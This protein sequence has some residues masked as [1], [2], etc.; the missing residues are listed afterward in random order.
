M[1]PV[2][3]LLYCTVCASSQVLDFKETFPH[4]LEAMPEFNTQ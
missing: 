2:V 4:T 3:M 1:S